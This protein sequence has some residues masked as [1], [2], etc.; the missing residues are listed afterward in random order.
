MSEQHKILMCMGTSGIA[1]DGRRGM[2]TGG[3]IG[4][5]TLRRDGFASMHGAGTLTTRPVR[6]KG[7]NLFVNFEGRLRVEFSTKPES[8]LARPKPFPATAPGRGSNCP[9]LPPER[10]SGSNFGFT[11]TLDRSTPSG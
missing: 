6:F 5:A 9:D 3:S 8:S 11:S 7:D 10:A 2:Y 1:P 4:L